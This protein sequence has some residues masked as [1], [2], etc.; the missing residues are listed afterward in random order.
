MMRELWL[1]RHAQAQ[2]AVEDGSDFARPLTKRGYA[3]TQRLRA[4]LQ[5]QPLLPDKTIASPANRAFTTA[6]C[7]Y[8]DFPAWQTAIIPDQR[9]YL[10]GVPTIKQVIAEQPASL[11]R[12]LLVGHNPDFEELLAE[13][14]IVNTRL[15]LD[16]A[17]LAI[18]TFSVDWQNLAPQKARLLAYIDADALND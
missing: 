4:W 18:L 8:A 7:F 14:M 15:T 3:A 2:Q 17:T 10:Q 13:L 12:L 16:T 1:L 5:Q 6:Y 9:L 11:Q